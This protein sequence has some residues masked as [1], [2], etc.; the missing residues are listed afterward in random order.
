[1]N[2]EMEAEL[3]KKLSDIYAQI[4]KVNKS[5]QGVQEDINSF[6]LSIGNV[7]DFGSELYIKIFIVKSRTTEKFST[8]YLPDTVKKNIVRKIKEGLILSYKKLCLEREQL[9]QEL[10]ECLLDS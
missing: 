5:I 10:K 6:D 1:M 3:T 8:Y 4:E 2:I 7:S 9:T